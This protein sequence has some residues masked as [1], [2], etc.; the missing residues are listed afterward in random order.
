MR[1]RESGEDWSR[2][3]AEKRLADRLG[4]G[5]GKRLKEETGAVGGD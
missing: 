5:D 4:G 1:W 3:S 2:P